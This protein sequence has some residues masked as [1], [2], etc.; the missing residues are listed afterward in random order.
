MNVVIDFMDKKPAWNIKIA[1]PFLEKLVHRN[2]DSSLEV[3]ARQ[4][5]DDVLLQLIRSH[6]IKR[7]RVLVTMAELVNC[8]SSSNSQLQADQEIL[9][10]RIKD[11]IYTKVRPPGHVRSQDG[12]HEDTI[13]ECTKT[14]S[15]KY[16]QDW[17]QPKI[18]DFGR[19]GFLSDEDAKMLQAGYC[20]TCGF[21]FILRT[22][23]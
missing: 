14:S 11:A 21:R 3:E 1:K 6:T 7:A 15:H 13:W 4:E 17:N 5:G 19:V 18:W 9:V 12:I 8:N 10:Q 23:K 16:K 22:P 20:P 2:I